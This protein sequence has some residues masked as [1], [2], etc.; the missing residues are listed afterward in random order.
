MKQIKI[1]ALSSLFL[2]LVTSF[3]GCHIGDGPNCKVPEIQTQYKYLKQPIPKLQKKPEFIEYNM[4]MVSFRDQDFYAIP[5]IDGYTLKTNWE[6]YRIWAE[7][8]Y[9][10]L[11]IIQ[12]NNENNENNENNITILKEDKDGNK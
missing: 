4:I 6:L 1:I 7:D 11:E 2:I 9:K 10:I 5:K 3:T 8:N 12:N